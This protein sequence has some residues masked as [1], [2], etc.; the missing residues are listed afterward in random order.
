MNWLKK[1]INTIIDGLSNKIDKSIIINNDEKNEYINEY[2]NENINININNYNYIFKIVNSKFKS[3]DILFKKYDDITSKIFDTI[4]DVNIDKYILPADEID[5]I[6]LG[7]GLKGYYVFGCLLLLKKMMDLNKIKIRK[8]IGISAGAFLAIFLFANFDPQI[9]RNINDFAFKNNTSYPIDKILLKICW[10]IF[11]ENIH[12]LINGKVTILISKGTFGNDKEK[13]V[14]YFKSKLHLMQVLHASSFI[15]FITSNNFRGVEIDGEK[16]F[17]GVF[18]NRNPTNFNN[19]IPQ[20]VFHT[21]KVN[22]SLFNSIYFNDPF[23]ELIMIKGILDFELF[24]KNN[25]KSNNKIPIKWIEPYH[26]NNIKNFKKI[27]NIKNNIKFKNNI[28]NLLL[29]IIFIILKLI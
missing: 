21:S 1:N 26:N 2:N 16:Y 4:K 19:D 14:T 6:V 3:K 8:F 18:S 10:E 11:P 12:E 29:I 22:Y 25:L 15:P 20:L 28:Y 5:C 9:I 17:D 7:G 24:I 13:Y 23:P 27:N